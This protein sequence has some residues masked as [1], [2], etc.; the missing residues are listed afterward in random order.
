MSGLGNP[1]ASP[2]GGGA[3]G[4][5]GLSNGAMQSAAA[6][7]EAAKK[8]KLA[9]DMDLKKSGSGGMPS[10]AFQALSGIGMI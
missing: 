6:I 10:S 4:D 2:T 5:L 3:I 9:D 8:K 1:L 7:A